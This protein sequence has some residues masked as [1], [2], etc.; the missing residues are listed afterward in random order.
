MKIMNIELI[1]QLVSIYASSCIIFI[2]KSLALFLISFS[3]KK[4][5]ISLEKLFKKYSSLG[6]V[7]QRKGFCISINSYHCDI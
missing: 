1:L 7:T 3:N 4:G 5:K 6:V 2:I